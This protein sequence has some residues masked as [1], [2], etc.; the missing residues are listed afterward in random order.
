SLTQ[1]SGFGQ[2]ISLLH[3]VLDSA[4]SE[5]D[6]YVVDKGIMELVRENTNA[7]GRIIDSLQEI[8]SLLSMEIKRTELSANDIREGLKEVV[9][10]VAKQQKIRNHQIVLSE[11]RD[12]FSHIR[13]E[14]NL[15]QIKRLF[16]ELLL[17]AMKFSPEGTSISVLMRQQTNKLNINVLNE[18]K[19]TRE[20]GNGQTEEGG[21]PLQYQ[22]LVF[23]PFFRLEHSVFED[24]ESL[25]IGMGLNIVRT[26]ADKL[27][28]SIAASNVKDFSD[29]KNIGD[30][31]LVD[32]ELQLPLLETTA[33][34]N[35]ARVAASA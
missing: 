31:I 12:A 25:D 34:T 32:F 18:V 9:Q 21:I 27:G 2:L 5:G 7:A 3:Y 28:G 26:I 35:T 23:E 11:A 6:H 1:G 10:Q 33:E 22:N 19:P 8:D 20:K 4:R 24:F 13:L 29:T 15:D 14:T 16:R 30:R 17:N